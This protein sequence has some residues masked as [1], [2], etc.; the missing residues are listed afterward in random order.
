MSWDISVILNRVNRA[1][2]SSHRPGLKR[3]RVAERLRTNVLGK[4][5]E[6]WIEDENSCRQEA[7]DG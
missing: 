4:G 6:S 7:V 2:G 3:K 1:R 5:V